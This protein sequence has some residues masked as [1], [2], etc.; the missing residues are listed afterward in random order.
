MAK[1]NIFQVSTSF[2]LG[3]TIMTPKG[4]RVVMFLNA[5]DTKK[6]W[7]SLDPSI[8]VPLFKSN[9]KCSSI[10]ANG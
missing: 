5:S 4:V 7:S 9:G 8:E 10:F 2:Y 6:E 3:L 1:I